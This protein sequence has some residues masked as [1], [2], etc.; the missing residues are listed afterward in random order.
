MCDYVSQSVKHGATLSV[1][2]LGI[3]HIYRSSAKAMSILCVQV[4]YFA[5]AHGYCS[6]SKLFRD[7]CSCAI[8]DYWIVIVSLIEDNGP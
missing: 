5:I 2:T 3:V 7:Y 8:T 4:K 1:Q 6:F